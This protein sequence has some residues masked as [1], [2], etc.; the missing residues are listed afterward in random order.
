MHLVRNRPIFTTRFTVELD[1]ILVVDTHNFF[2]DSGIKELALCWSALNAFDSRD[3]A[4]R[5]IELGFGTTEPSAGDTAMEAP[6]YS[7]DV[8]TS[9]FVYPPE[10]GIEIIGKFLPNEPISNSVLNFTEFGLFAYPVSNS[11]EKVLL[12]R[13]VVDS[14]VPKSPSVEMTIRFFHKFELK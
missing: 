13:V 8:D 14:G 12:S 1:G 9:D 10:G 4:P 11:A 6:F 5:S 3:H 7:K 2:V